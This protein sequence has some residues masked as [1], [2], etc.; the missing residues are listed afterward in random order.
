MKP[1]INKFSKSAHVDAETDQNERNILQ[2]L[3]KDGETYSQ[4]EVKSIVTKWKK[5]EVKS[6]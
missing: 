1:K 6:K 4:D 2:I 5:K 3:L